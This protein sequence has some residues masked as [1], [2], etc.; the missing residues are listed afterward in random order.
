MLKKARDGDATAQAYA[1]RAAEAANDYFGLYGNQGVCLRG[2][3][4]GINYCH[5]LSK[6]DSY[7]GDLDLLMREYTKQ[8]V[9]FKDKDMEP[10]YW[11]LGAAKAGD[12]H[13]QY[14]VGKIYKWTR[15]SELPYLEESA[16]WLRAAAEQ[17]LPEAQSEYAG[18]LSDDRY[19]D[20]AGTPLDLAA[21]FDLSMKAAQQ[22]DGVGI[23]RV[24]YA[25]LKGWGTPVNYAEAYFWASLWGYGFVEPAWH[26]TAEEVTAIQ[27]RVEAWQPVL[28]GSR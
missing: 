9:T 23:G 4:R 10:I 26:L 18:V 2:A 13:A 5:L 8:R 21:A 16:R 14:T 11:C 27:A 28:P 3:E 7:I 12:A 25:Y 6:A 22:G 1:C 19:H 20:N 15:T 24:A 17:G